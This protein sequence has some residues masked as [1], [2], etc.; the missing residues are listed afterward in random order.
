MLI[1]TMEIKK[2]FKKLTLR[3]AYLCVKKCEDVHILLFLLLLKES[4]FNRN[5][6]KAKRQR[7]TIEHQKKR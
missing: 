5:V 3:I 6:I 7:S 2:K 1:G 4:F